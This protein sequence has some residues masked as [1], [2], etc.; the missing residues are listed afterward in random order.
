MRWRFRFSLLTV[1]FTVVLLT[2]GAV[3]TSIEAGLAVPD[4][5]T[6]FNSV[7]PLNPIAR[8]WAIP[9]I[10][11]EHGHRLMGLVVG[12]SV[13]ILAGWTLLCE[14]RSWVKKV[15]L[16]AL[17][18]VVFQGVLG[19][20][21]VVLVSLDLAIV[22]ACVAQLFFSTLASL[23]LFTSPTWL[24][25][26]GILSEGLETTQLRRVAI[27][28]AMA[29]Y[30]QIILGALLRH[31]GAGENLL[32]ATNHMLGALAVLGLILI[33]VKRVSDLRSR[34]RTVNTLVY[35]LLGILAIQIVLGFATYFVITGD[36]EAGRS[37]L[38]TI[39]STAHMVV[40]AFLLATSVLVV[41]SSARS[42]SSPYTEAAS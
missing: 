12:A 38:P 3:V 18:L 35:S 6:T 19:G 8:W 2:W 37:L 36:A 26:S 17:G 21:R 23:A 10:L 7:D 13:C 25:A 32:L 30:I 33:T 5:P 41:L 24:R 28:T 39:I 31:P 9:S 4:W 42:V 11:A 27:M 16:V 40:G 14:S 1:F 15:A 22:H 29:I 20:L 34:S